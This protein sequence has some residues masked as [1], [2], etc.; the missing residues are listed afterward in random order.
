MH[1]YYLLTGNNSVSL[2]NL[3]IMVLIGTFKQFNIKTVCMQ[4]DWR[5]NEEKEG[6]KLTHLDCYLL[7]LPFLEPLPFFPLLVPASSFDG[8]AFFGF[9]F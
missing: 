2:G 8:G 1:V 7:S 4:R 6:L 5:A 3:E 9:P